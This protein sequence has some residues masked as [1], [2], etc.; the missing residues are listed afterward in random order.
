MSPER[1]LHLVILVLFAALLFALLM[2]VWPVELR[3]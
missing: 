3:R 2:H 1:L